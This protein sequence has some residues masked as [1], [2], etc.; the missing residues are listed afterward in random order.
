MLFFNFEYTSA[1]LK[2]FNHITLHFFLALNSMSGILF[3]DD[4]SEVSKVIQVF[5]CMKSH[6]KALWSSLDHH[7]WWQNCNSLAKC[8]VSSP[9]PWFSNLTLC[10]SNS[11]VLFKTHYGQVPC[12]ENLIH[13]GIKWE[14]TIYISLKCPGGV[15]STGLMITFHSFLDWTCHQGV[16]LGRRPVSVAAHICVWGL[17]FGAQGGNI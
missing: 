7:K 4:L 12:P 14:Q 8:G 10:Q 1:C 16:K 9:I 15:D 2:L 3:V 5:G 6:L 17:K 13:W 11:R